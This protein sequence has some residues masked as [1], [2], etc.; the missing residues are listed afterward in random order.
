MTAYARIVI[1]I[2]CV[3]CVGS[4]AALLT[5]ASWWRWVAAPALIL[6]GW[7]ALGHLVTLDDDA[8]SGWSSPA[9]REGSMRFFR[10][11]LAELAAKALVF[12]GL[13]WFVSI[14]WSRWSN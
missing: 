12:G 1:G 4:V 8:P 14:D 3:S 13:V 2:F 5:G 9:N 6:S 7:A 10:S 11:S